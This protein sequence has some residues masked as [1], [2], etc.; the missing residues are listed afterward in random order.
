MIIIKKENI[1]KA[2]KNSIKHRNKDII[3]PLGKGFGIIEIDDIN[4]GVKIYERK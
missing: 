2:I 4:I 3:E 1:I